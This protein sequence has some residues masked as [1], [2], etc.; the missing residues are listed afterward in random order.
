[1]KKQ[2]IKIARLTKKEAQDYWDKLTD[3]ECS[4]KSWIK[5][6]FNFSELRWEWYFK[7]KPNYE[8]EELSKTTINKLSEWADNIN[9][10]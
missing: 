9:I 7:Y 10:K 5:P 8:I 4:F 6:R 2:M 3:K 1:M